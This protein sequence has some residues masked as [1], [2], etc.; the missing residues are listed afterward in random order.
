MAQGVW[1]L[2]AVGEEE[3]TAGPAEC[4]Q[5]GSRCEHLALSRWRELDDEMVYVKVTDLIPDT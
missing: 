1:G 3:D 4:H 2:R 5:E